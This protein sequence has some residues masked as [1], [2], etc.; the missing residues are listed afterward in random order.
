M[1]ASC[2]LL[3]GAGAVPFDSPLCNV[4]AGEHALLDQAARWEYTCSC[5]GLECNKPT[6]EDFERSVSHAFSELL[7]IDKLLRDGKPLGKQTC[8]GDGIAVLNTLIHWGKKSPPSGE[9][10]QV[11]FFS[12]R[13]QYDEQLYAPELCFTPGLVCEQCLLESRALDDVSRSP[14][15][16]ESHVL[17]SRALTRRSRLT[18]T[19]RL[20]AEDNDEDLFLC[21]QR[22]IAHMGC[23]PQGR[24]K[25]TR[26]AQTTRNS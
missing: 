16:F 3:C 13:P 17:E 4:V 14:A 10:R 19:G 2:T 23:I 15:V 12:V 20:S 9:K 18:N 5:D 21:C 24:P 1:C 8:A 22:S 6:P 11:L 7:D 25:P 26:L